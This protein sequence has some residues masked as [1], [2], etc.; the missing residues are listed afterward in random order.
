MPLTSL[1]SRYPDG[2][3]V[4]TRGSVSAYPEND[5]DD[6]GW[7]L[8]DA[9][10]DSTPAS[11]LE[12]AAKPAVDIEVGRTSA[13]TN[14][15]P[16]NEAI[17]ASTT[18]IPTPSNPFMGR[19]NGTSTGSGR[20]QPTSRSRWAES[21]RGKRR[22]VLYDFVAAEDNEL[23]VVAGEDVLLLNFD[24][25]AD[26][27]LVA[28]NKLGEVGWVPRAY[29]QGLAASGGEGGEGLKGE[30]EGR[31]GK[32][33]SEGRVGQRRGV[34]EDAE[35]EESADEFVDALAVP[36]SCQKRRRSGSGLDD[37]DNW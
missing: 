5:P 24:G 19:R 32:E 8:V 23:S 22:T 29:V 31:E 37:D 35:E 6:D 2:I 9:N 16:S 21:N 4:C 15:T 18:S 34:A 33:E 12:A 28:E 11:Q 13:S 25:D 3:I 30:R 10:G 7:L 17:P 27:W 1:L 14:T 20:K 36:L 26:G